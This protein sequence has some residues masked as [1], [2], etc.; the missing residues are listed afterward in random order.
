MTVA[1][2]PATHGGMWIAALAAL[3]ALAIASPRLPALALGLGAAAALG[4]GFFA[5]PTPLVLGPTGLLADGA[6]ALAVLALSLRLPART[7]LPATVAALAAEPVLACV[8]LAALAAQTRRPKLAAGLAL[9]AAGFFFWINGFADARVV[10]QLR[11]LPGFAALLG[12]VALVPTGARAAA[13]GVWLLAL[14]RFGLPLFPEGFAVLAPT[15]AWVA[16]GAAVAL[17]LGA[18]RWPGPAALVP[19]GRWA[20]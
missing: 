14:A 7:L 12:L 18:W 15:L 1:A 19:L 6:A 10:V 11:A 17:G 9:A 20:R 13:A 5:P 8:A 16:G 4:L 2:A 3:L